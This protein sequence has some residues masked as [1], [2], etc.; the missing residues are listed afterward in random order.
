MAKWL[1]LMLLFPSLICMSL[2]FLAI[3]SVA[4]YLSSFWRICMT[5]EKGMKRKVN[6]ST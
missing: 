4:T 6:G 2:I 1:A 3:I 5:L